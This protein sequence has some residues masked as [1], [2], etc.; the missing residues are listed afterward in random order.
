MGIAYSNEIPKPKATNQE[1]AAE[2]R[3][4]EQSPLFVK[5]TSP[6]TQ[7]ERDHEAYE[8]YEKPANERKITDATIALA[9]ITG[10][11][12]FFTA[13]LWYATYKL[14]KDAKTSG[15]TQATKMEKSIA[16]ATR[17]ASAMESVAE[18]T[19]NNAILMQGILH[20]QMRAY[21]AFDSAGC[22]PQDASTNWKFEVRFHI[23][24]FGHSPAQSVNVNS[25]LVIL[26]TPISDNFNPVIPVE[27][28]QSAADIS[29]GQSFFFR[30][31][32]TKLLSD[33]EIICIKKM[34][35]KAMCLHGTVRYK[36][37]FGDWHDTNFFKVCNWD[38]KDLFSVVNVGR[39]NNTT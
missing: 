22:V 28:K 2:Q 12:A 14:A 36:D 1:S 27:E 10:I 3:G 11:L 16:E 38:V 29:P 23:K 35:G 8:K 4:S 5:A 13:A 32:L 37:I 17:A 15:E 26:D 7:A 39:H 19:K 34:D 20:K 33:E 31:N 30:T 21:L 6:N 25:A 9:W 24:N 18:A